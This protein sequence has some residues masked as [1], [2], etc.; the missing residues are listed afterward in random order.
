MLPVVENGESRFHRMNV[1]GP[2][3]KLVRTIEVSTNP[4]PREA[5]P[6]LDRYARTPSAFRASGQPSYSTRYGFWARTAAG[7]RETSKTAQVPRSSGWPKSTP[8][9]TSATFTPFPVYP[10]AFASMAWWIR[11]ENDAVGLIPGSLLIDGACGLPALD[12]VESTAVGSPSF[13]ARTS[14]GDR[15]SFWTVVVRSAP[16]TSGEDSTTSG[17]RTC[18]RMTASVLSIRLTSWS[19][20]AGNFR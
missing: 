3:V 20:Y 5:T 18:S 15:T 10:F 16:R 2:T 19:A 7:T 14:S 1:S 6:E 8:K 12:W 4:S 17:F 11:D 13:R 9:S